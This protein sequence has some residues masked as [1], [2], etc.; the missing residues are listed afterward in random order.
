[1]ARY[2]RSKYDEALDYDGYDGYD[3]YGGYN[4]YRD[5]RQPIY[6]FQAEPYE[7]CC[8]NCRFFKR[9]LCSIVDEFDAPSPDG[10]DCC[11]RFEPKRRR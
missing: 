9:R 1:M 6:D 2:G 7:E 3:E 10:S 11:D 5:E 8:Y 4:V